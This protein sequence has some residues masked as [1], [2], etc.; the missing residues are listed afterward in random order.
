MFVLITAIQVRQLAAVELRKRVS[1]STTSP[2]D[3]WTAVSQNERDVIKAKLP[4]I[5][6]KEQRFVRIPIDIS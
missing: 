5:T 1:A 4:E 3:M 6:L 2:G